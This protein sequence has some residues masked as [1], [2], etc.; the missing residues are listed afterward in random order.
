[1]VIKAFR[2][3]YLILLA[4][5]LANSFLLANVSQQDTKTAQKLRPFTQF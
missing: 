5:L 1:M 4:N 3:K 2:N